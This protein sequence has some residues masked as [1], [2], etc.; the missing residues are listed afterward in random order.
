[1]RGSTQTLVVAIGCTLLT[2][3]GAWP[4]QAAQQATESLGTAS[5]AGTMMVPRQHHTATLLPD[6]RV[7]VVGGRN[8]DDYLSTAEVW[9]P[10]T[11]SFEQTGSLVMARSG[12][13][14]FVQPDGSVVVVGG[15]G[16]TQGMPVAEGERWDPG[17]GA[18]EPAGA[19]TTPRMEATVTELSDGRVLVVGGRSYVD[20]ERTEPVVE[21][22]IWDPATSTFK[23]AGSIVHPREYHTTLALP[24][25]GAIVIGGPSREALYWNPATGTFESAGRMAEPRNDAVLLADGRVL[26]IGVVDPITCKPGKRYAR[27]PDAE[28]WDPRTFSFEPAGAFREPRRPMDVVALDDGRVLAYGGWNAVCMDSIAL[29]TAEAWDPTALDF[30]HAGKTRERREHHTTTLLPDGRVAFIGGMAEVVAME[31]RRFTRLKDVSQDEVELWDPGADRFVRGGKI[32]QRRAEHTAALLGNGSILLVGGSAALGEG[33]LA[34]AE[35]W[36]P[37]PAGRAGGVGTDTPELVL[38]LPSGIPVGIAPAGEMTTR[39]SEHTADLLDD[40][41][42]LIVGGADGS[43]AELFEPE[44]GMFAPTGSMSESR[45]YH[46][47][48]RMGDGTVLVVGGLNEPATAEIYD[49]LTGRFTPT[50]APLTQ[51]GAAEAILLRDGRVLGISGPSAELYDPR[52][53]AFSLLTESGLLKGQGLLASLPDGRVLVVGSNRRRG[54]AEAALFDPASGTFSPVVVDREL[55]DGHTLTSLPDGR[56]LLAGGWADLEASHLYDPASGTFEPTGHLRVPR[57]EHEAVA[58]P[59]GRVLLFGGQDKQGQTRSIEAFDPVT[60]TYTKVGRLKEVRAGFTATLLD[61]GR[62]LIAG[63]GGVGERGRPPR[64]AEV[65]DPETGVS[66]FTGSPAS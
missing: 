64:H 19:L 49:P 61:D 26:T 27:T 56:V 30:G 37:P 21:A 50:G 53:R 4:A 3:A 45:V 55:L 28:L 5:P 66:T 12:H 59:D 54:Q 24:D 34:S 13:A 1:M 43:P 10:A 17:T 6:G 11:R 7:L 47:A 23:P 38:P 57:A 42:V 39:R 44:T 32:I 40:G 14:A 29:R 52:T 35:I 58:L 20:A 18:F 36:T 46:T 15:W 33:P 8:E 9:D 2:G 41:R 60:G 51:R 48:T 65:F 25:G 31:T 16:G 22:E 63:G 62:V